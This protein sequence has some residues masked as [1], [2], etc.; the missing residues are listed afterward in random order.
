MSRTVGTLLPSEQ[1]GHIG[2]EHHLYWSHRV[3]EPPTHG[4]LSTAEACLQP[5]RR[6]AVHHRMDRC[7]RKRA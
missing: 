2:L 3:A 4:Y 7:W 1:R 6:C 5:K